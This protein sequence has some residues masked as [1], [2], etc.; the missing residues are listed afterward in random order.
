LATTVSTGLAT[1]FSTTFSTGLA[2]VTGAVSVFYYPYS[3]YAFIASRFI[4]QRLGSL[5]TTVFTTF[6]FSSAPSTRLY[7]SAIISAT[8]FFSLS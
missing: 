8:I 3:Y 1:T 5:V 6:L 2:S 7:F 4:H